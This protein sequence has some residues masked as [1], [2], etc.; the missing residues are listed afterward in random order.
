VSN[1]KAKWQITMPEKFTD[2]IGEP[3]EFPKNPV[4]MNEKTGQPI[5]EPAT[6]QRILVV[7]IR[8]M[9]VKTGEDAERSYKL[10]SL[11]KD[12][13]PSDVVTMTFG[14]MDWLID[15]IKEHAYAKTDKT[16]LYSAP[17]AALL[18]TYLKE[19]FKKV[20]DEEKTKE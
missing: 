12:A 5:T 14:D 9:P 4:E 16:G 11:F 7:T 19:N 15:Q 13:K 18:W 3:W 8:R 1:E 17:D 20:G 10:V 6:L 2:C